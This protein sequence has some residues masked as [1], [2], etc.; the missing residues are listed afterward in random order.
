MN[1]SVPSYPIYRKTLAHSLMLFVL[2]IVLYSP[3]FPDMY[4]LW[5]ENSNN[6][7]GLLVPFVSLYLMWTKRGN[8]EWDRTTPSNIGLLILVVSLLC[9]IIGYAGGIEVL[10]RLTI[11]I[12]LIGLIIFNLGLEFFSLISF[13]ILFL[14]FMIPFP[15]SIVG[16]VSFPLQLFA[17]EV[18]AFIISSLSI[19]VF[20]TGNMLHFAN[21]SLEVAEACSGIR[22]L[23]SYLM[24][25]FLFAYLMNGSV[26]RRSIMVL[27]AIP[28]AFF[29]NILRVTSTG[30]LAHC[31]GGDVARGF[32]H[33]FSG[34]SFFVFG[35]IIFVFCYVL[36]EKSHRGGLKEPKL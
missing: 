17:T 20:I 13:P 23:V 25:G 10:P 9:Y 14:F 36:L 11:V 5:I 2:F 30:I 12:T 22:S 4:H 7:H 3:I 31:L 33:E 21:T 28:L 26:K 29:S 35:F 16:L 32:L 24:L 6:S 19:P 1:L 18:S 27:L 15:V 34:I 8:I